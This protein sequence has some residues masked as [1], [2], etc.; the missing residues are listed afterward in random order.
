MGHRQ[1]PEQWI[2][3][4]PE[5]VKFVR[6]YL[7]KKI[8]FITENRFLYFGLYPE[9]ANEREVSLVL[10]ALRD[11]MEAEGNPA[12]AQLYFDKLRRA[13]DRARYAKK[14]ATVLHSFYLDKDTNVKFNR[15]LTKL[16]KTKSELISY[17]LEKELKEAPSP[18][19]LVALHRQIEQLSQKRDVAE[20]NMQTAFTDLNELVI[21]LSTKAYEYEI[22][23]NE[24]EAKT[25]LADEVK[26]IVEQHSS[27]IERFKKECVPPLQETL[28]KR[29]K[30]KHKPTLLE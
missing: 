16:K 24:L 2:R 23:K 5:K 27:E 11:G 25:E 15:A 4:N 14:H 3:E 18:V 7:E 26:K 29:R 22:V 9:D 28:N 10:R 6:K 13:W 30:A 21:E 17:L 19:N 20:Q 8:G 1:T 12:Y